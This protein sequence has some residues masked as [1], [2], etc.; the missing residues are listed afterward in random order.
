MAKT[1]KGVSKNEKK[2]SKKEMIREK[3]HSSKEYK[4]KGC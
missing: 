1:K 4:S 2:H 3:K